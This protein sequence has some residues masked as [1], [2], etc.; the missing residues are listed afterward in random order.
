MTRTEFY[1][2]IDHWISQE[3]SKWNHLTLMAYFYHKYN[4]RTGVNFMPASWKSNPALTKESRDFSKLF[5]LFA[6]DNYKS[7]SKEVKKEIRHEVNQKIYNY[8]NWMFDYKFRFGIKTV[9]GLERI[10]DIGMISKYIEMY[11]LDASTPESKLVKQAR[12]FKL[13]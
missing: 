2:R 6:P 4:K 12:E 5:K 3:K 8:I 9:T 11:N 10:D 13:I 7:C 1:Q